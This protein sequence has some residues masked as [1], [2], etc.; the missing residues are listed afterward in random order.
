MS[1]ESGNLAVILTIVSQED[2]FNSECYLLR[3]TVAIDQLLQFVA[4]SLAQM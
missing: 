2:N 4:F 1:N 3:S